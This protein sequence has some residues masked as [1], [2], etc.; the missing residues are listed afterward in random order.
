[1]SKLTI[2]YIIQILFLVGTFFA[3][4]FSYAYG[5][6]AEVLSGLEMLYWLILLVP[7]ALLIMSD[8]KDRSMPKYHA[9]WAVLGIIG[10]LIYHFGFARKASVKSAK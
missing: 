1:M 2:V 6:L 10:V 9:W 4:I 8:A 7:T 5:M 3:S